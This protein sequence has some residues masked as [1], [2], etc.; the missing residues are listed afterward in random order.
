[1][2]LAGRQQRMKQVGL[3][4]LTGTSCSSSV[5]FILCWVHGCRLPL[6][7]HRVYKDYIMVMRITKGHQSLHL[8]SGEQKMD[9]K[10]S[11]RSANHIVSIWSVFVLFRHD[12]IPVRWDFLCCI[13]Q[14]EGTLLSPPSPHTTTKVTQWDKVFHLPGLL[15]RLF[16]LICLMDC[17]LPRD[18]VQ[19]VVKCTARG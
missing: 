13:K 5:F 11:L 12:H 18:Y 15:Q 16:V 4:S 17:V 2:L 19:I 8:H 10:F 3:P 9:L 6:Y 1:M 7:R 14:M